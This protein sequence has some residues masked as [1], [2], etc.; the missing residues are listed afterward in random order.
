MF[1]QLTVTPSITYPHGETYYGHPFEVRND[2]EANKYVRE[3]Q[4]KV[5]KLTTEDHVASWKLTSSP[6]T[7]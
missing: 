2:D 5:D 6:R 7:Y 3:L 4:E 1:I